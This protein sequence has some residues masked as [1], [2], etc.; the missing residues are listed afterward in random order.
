MGQSK[1]DRVYLVIFAKQ[2]DVLVSSPNTLFQVA[3]RL[4]EVIHELVPLRV[5]NTYLRQFSLDFFPRQQAARI[6][7]DLSVTLWYYKKKGALERPA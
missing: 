1:V 3:L 2:Q 5:I 6:F 7:P 4:L